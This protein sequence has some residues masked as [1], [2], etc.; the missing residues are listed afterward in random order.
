MLYVQDLL[1]LEQHSGDWH[2]RHWRTNSAKYWS[3]YIPGTL[4]AR[5]IQQRAFELWWQ[6]WFAS[7]WKLK[8]CLG[9]SFAVW[10]FRPLGVHQKQELQMELQNLNA[11]AVCTWAQ[12]PVRICDTTWQIEN[13]NTRRSDSKKGFSII[14]LIMSLAPQELLFRAFKGFHKSA[15]GSE[16][17]PEDC[18]CA[19]RLVELCSEAMWSL[20]WQQTLSV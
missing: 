2:R 17:S 5:Q 13:R 18:A 3:G 4:H 8:I 1:V 10:Y 12:V 14:G 9:S 7:Q 16:P 11:D 20:S 15:K 6:V 19:K